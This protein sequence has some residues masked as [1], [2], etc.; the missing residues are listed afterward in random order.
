M[1]VSVATWN[2][3][4]ATP[5]SG[6]GRR[7]AAI[8]RTTGADIAVVT[9]G[10][11]DLL[12]A[13]GSVVDAG[14]DWGYGSKADRRKVIVWSRY[15]LTLDLQGVGGATEGRLAVAKAAT[16]AG[17]IRILGVCI[18]WRDAHVNTG[19]S[20][21]QPW[22]EHMDYLDRLGVLLTQL[23]DGVPT[24]IAGDF[25]Q[26][27]PRGRQPM[28]VA[29]R[30][31]DVLAN[32][33]IHT[34]DVMPNGPHIDHIA[35]D[36][37]FVLESLRDWP[38][39]DPIGRLSDHAGVACRLGYANQ[40]TQGAG[41]G[42]V[43]KRRKAERMCDVTPTP[44]QT[45]T[46]D[47]SVLFQETLARDGTL[48][49]EL[50]AEIEEVLRRSGDGLSHGATFRLREQGLSDA[51]IATERGVSIGT[52]RGFLRSLDALL[53]GMLPT[54]KSLAL[55][56]SYVYREL[57][58]HPRSEDLDSYVKAQLAKLK[59]INPDVRF[60]P[61]QTRAQ[62]Y[63]VGE[64]KQKTAIDDSCGK[65]ATVGIAAELFHDLLHVDVNATPDE[66]S[67]PPDWQAVYN[68]AVS[69]AERNLIRAL[70]GA[71]TAVPALGYETEDGEVIDL[72]WADAR[73][74]V[75]FDGAP[76]AEGWILCPADVPQILAALRTNGVI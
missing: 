33:K 55:T 66:P 31:N 44:T 26:R 49:A 36:G 67:L 45:P 54:T 52:T 21:A 8:L 69:D 18:P 10:V 15:P 61:L 6:R 27:I 58:N 14:G 56:N 38:G 70:A 63:R 73:V 5:G 12:P 75:T 50:L 11:R 4:W 64:R 53:N 16:P 17:P 62:Q 46:H 74:G 40:R 37:Q 72:A 47:R 51:Q 13:A 9:E 65:D 23:D 20:D 32:W 48:N 59:S 41:G 60:D 35:T 76:T 24:V 28:P 2:T 43:S 1:T 19:R 34:A 22:S 25:N 71:G 39:S 68:E 29:T 42:S 3:E 57:L 30:L 7:I